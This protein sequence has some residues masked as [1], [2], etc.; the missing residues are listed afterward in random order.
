MRSYRLK[1][2]DDYRDIPSTPLD[3][4]DV[5]DIAITEIAEQYGGTIVAW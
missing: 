5:G 1:I 3:W 2:V 4:G